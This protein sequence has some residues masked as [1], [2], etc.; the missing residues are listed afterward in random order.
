MSPMLRQPTGPPSH[1]GLRAELSIGERGAHRPA[2]IPSG[3][4]AVVISGAPPSFN[5]VF[6]VYTTVASLVPGDARNCATYSSA[7]VLDDRAPPHGSN[8]GAGGQIFSTSSWRV[9]Q[10]NRPN[11]RAYP[12]DRTAP[13]SGDAA[14]IRVR[15]H[16]A[17]PVSSRPYPVLALPCPIFTDRG[18]QR[19]AGSWQEPRGGGAQG[20]API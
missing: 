3:Q 17:R 4:N 14:A 12:K 16:S 7:S 2:K 20:C 5:L 19:R 11:P 9:A 8:G 13:C 10:S 6:T 18:P 15:R 1:R